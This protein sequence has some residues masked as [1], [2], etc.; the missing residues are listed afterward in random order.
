LAPRGTFL[1]FPTVPTIEVTAS[2][3]ALTI[4]VAVSHIASFTI[5]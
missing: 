1:A 5:F 2:D 3:Y 4:T